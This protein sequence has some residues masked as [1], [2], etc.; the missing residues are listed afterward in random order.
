MMYVF[1]LIGGLT[2]AATVAAMSLRRAVH[3]VLALAMGL[4]GVACIYLLLGAQFVGLTQ[5][6]VY[7]GAVAI[8][9]VFAIMTTQKSDSVEERNA[10]TMS[11][12]KVVSGVGTAVGVLVILVRVIASAPFGAGAG[13]APSVS[14]AQ[15]GT[16]LMSTYALPLE[17]IGL[18]LTA[19]FVGAVIVAMPE[20]RR[21]S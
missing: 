5:M 11:V 4:I 21:R 2:I 16:A 10:S 18:L 7:V 6:M 13:S 20:P 8:L 1:Y 15:I 12:W 14:V 9:A 19:A 3:C 17:V